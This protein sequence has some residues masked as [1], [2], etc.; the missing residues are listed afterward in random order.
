MQTQWSHQPI[1]HSYPWLLRQESQ[2]LQADKKIGCTVAWKTHTEWR[3]IGNKEAC[4]FS[5]LEIHRRIVS[6]S[7]SKQ[8]AISKQ[9]AVSPEEE[10]SNAQLRKKGKAVATRHAGELSVADQ[11]WKKEMSQ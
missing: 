8:Q 1:S 4:S 2:K 11:F 10:A 9:Q 7:L 5:K 3:R 6:S